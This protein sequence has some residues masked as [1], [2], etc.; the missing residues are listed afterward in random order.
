[1]TYDEVKKEL[2]SYRWALDKQRDLQAELDRWRATAENI[3]PNWSGM[4]GGGPSGAQIETS[5]EHILELTEQLE[6]QIQECIA[7]RAK[8]EQLIEL[9][10][11]PQHRSILR[12][13]YID[14]MSWREITEL[15]RY[16]ID[17]ARKLKREGIHKLCLLNRENHILGINI[18]K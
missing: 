11:K 9:A 17:Y 13:R 2:E 3:S 12:K 18:E 15:T 4:P 7:Q 16:D 5:V 14:C 1:M 8:V 10:E 6:Q